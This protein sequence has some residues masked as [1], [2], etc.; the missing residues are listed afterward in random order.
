MVMPPLWPLKFLEGYGSRGFQGNPDRLNLLDAFPGQGRGHL[1][2]GSGCRQHETVAH[3]PLEA[4]PVRDSAVDEV[5][6]P[7][8]GDGALCF[9]GRESTEIG[10]VAVKSLQCFLSRC[11]SRKL[12]TAL[13]GELLGN[14]TG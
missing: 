8:M 3:E 7:V 4:N 13:P 2:T 5:A 10:N 9:V 11:P 1:L 14:V 12:L 6:L